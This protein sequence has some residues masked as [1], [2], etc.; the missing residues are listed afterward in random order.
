MD[1]MMLFMCPFLSLPKICAFARGTENAEA[2]HVVITITSP[3]GT[4]LDY[5]IYCILSLNAI[6]SSGSHT[7]PFIES[8]SLLQKPHIIFILIVVSMTKGIFSCVHK[9]AI[10]TLE[11]I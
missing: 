11:Q 9:C 8:D 3:C 10:H 4:C 2:E 7:Q 5:S 1:F 6:E